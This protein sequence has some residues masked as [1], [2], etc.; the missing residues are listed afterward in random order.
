MFF[1]KFLDRNLTV[2]VATLTAVSFQIHCSKGSGDSAAATSNTPSNPSC[3]PTIL[4]GAGNCAL[5]LS[6]TSSI[7]AGPV[8]GTTTTGDA[9]ATGNAARFNQSNGITSDSTNIY[10]A[11]QLNN[12]I[13]KIVISTGVVT[14]LAGPAQGTTTAGDVDAT[15]NAARFSQ[16]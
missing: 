2:V 10:V 3:T 12:K 4:A 11:D 13:R 15:G 6:Y 16:P 14:T 7:L 8:Q 9:D 1:K 5:S